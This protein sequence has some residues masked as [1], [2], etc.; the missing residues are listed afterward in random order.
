MEFR[1][2]IELEYVQAAW[3]TVNVWPPMAM[4]PVRVLLVVFA[5]TLYATVP[6]PVPLAPPVMVIH[7]SV[8]AAVHEELLDNGVT[9]MLPVPDKELKP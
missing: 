4:V 6:L 8:V 5:A 3:V 9:V 7:E 1:A 2:P